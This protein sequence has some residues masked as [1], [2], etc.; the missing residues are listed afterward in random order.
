MYL[1]SKMAEIQL[2][3]LENKL[4][5]SEYFSI[6]SG[7]YDAGSKASV[8]WTPPTGVD[9]YALP[10]SSPLALAAIQ[11]TSADSD[12]DAGP[13]TSPIHINYINEH[14]DAM[15]VLGTFGQLNDVYAAPTTS[16]AAGDA[17][18]QLHRLSR[19][20]RMVGGCQADYD[21]Q[22]AAG[23][24]SSGEDCIS[25][26]RAIERLQKRRSNACRKTSAT[27]AAAA[28]TGP[29][30][31][32]SNENNT[33][34][35][36]GRGYGYDDDCDDDD[37][38]NYAGVDVERRRARLQVTASATSNGHSIGKYDFH[39]SVSQ[40][41]ERKALLLR[42]DVHLTAG[43]S[44][45]VA[46]AAASAASAVVESGGGRRLA[47][48]AASVAS[49]SRNKKRF[50][51]EYYYS[52]GNVFGHDDDDDDDNGDNDANGVVCYRDQHVGVHDQHG[53]RH[54]YHQP[55]LRH[56]HHQHHHHPHHSP[57]VLPTTHLTGHTAPVSVPPASTAALAK[58]PSCRCCVPGSGS[59]ASSLLTMGGDSSA[60]TATTNSS[61]SRPASASS[62]S[63]SRSASNSGGGGS[64]SGGVAATVQ[65]IAASAAA[66][67]T[68]A[69]VGGGV[70]GS[71]QTGKQMLVVNQCDN[72]TGG[73]V[74]VSLLQTS[75]SLPEMKPIRTAVEVHHHHHHHHHNAAIG[76]GR[77]SGR[78]DGEDDVG[79]V[80]GVDG[81][82]TVQV[83]A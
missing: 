16:T 63:S 45:A 75:A 43:A 19:P 51:N 49:S 21:L 56:H 17:G 11:T 58:S 77:A 73:G 35:T 61:T 7:Y 46:A 25:R 24:F 54:H 60:S 79:D 65:T 34:T 10:L 9:G 42:D 20:E 15:M 69:G 18:L 13:Q 26:M 67:A 59:L 47:V 2:R 37:D 71:D 82:V 74:V 70:G 52:V 40:P 83:N 30:R 76:G 29:L 8:Y 39:R 32:S 53:L 31:T 81:K 57:V 48:A 23:G 41:H 28:A 36:A 62:Q 80:A 66:A 5:S 4:R 64:G 27:V 6:R 44:A 38:D 1:K 22:G 14:P 72:G 3:N 78:D 33:S 50:N 68:A 12:P 55:H